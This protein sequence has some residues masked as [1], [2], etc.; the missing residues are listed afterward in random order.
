MFVKTALKQRKSGWVVWHIKP[1]EL[2]NDKLHKHT[3]THTHTH[4][5]IYIYI[6]GLQPNSS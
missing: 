5:H 3:H 6:H 1:C 2:S 4:T